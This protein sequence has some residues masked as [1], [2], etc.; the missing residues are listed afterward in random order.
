MT[1]LADAVAFVDLETTG[2]TAVRDRVTEVAIVRVVEGEVVEEWSTLVDPECPIPEDI[3]ALTGITNEMVR[4]AP[5]FARISREVLERLEAAARYEQKRLS[6][7]AI[8]QNQARHPPRLYG[9]AYPAT[10]NTARRQA[11]PASAWSG[12]H[13]PACL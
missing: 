10:W 12:L 9:G 3:Q 11:A 4:G 1:R 13:A 6:L 5:T 8:L 7:R 2:T